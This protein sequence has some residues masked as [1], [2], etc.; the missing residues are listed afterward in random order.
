MRIKLSTRMYLQFSA[1]V[2]PL[3]L[4]LFF[5]TTATSDLP[6]QVA[7]TLAAFDMAL[8]ASSSYKKFLNGVGDAVDTG[9]LGSKALEALAAAHSKTAALVQVQPS[10]VIQKTLEQ[11]AAIEKSV[12]AKNSVETLIALRTDVSNADA[13]VAATIGEVT[14]RLSSIVAEEDQR[15]RRKALRQAG[16]G[17]LTLLI[18]GFIVRQMVI[19]ITR[20]IALAVHTAQLVAK[21]DLSTT[22]EVGRNDEI[23][24]LQQALRDMAEA[25][26]LIVGDVRAGTDVIGQVSGQIGS[27]NL[28]LSVRTEQQTASLQQ[29]SASIKKMTTTVKENADNAQLANQLAASASEVAVK[30]GTVV[31]QVVQTMGSINAS[32]KKIVDIIGVIDSIAFQTNILALNAAV[33]AAR[34]GEQ[35]RGFAVVATEVRNLAQRSAAAAREIKALIGDSVEKV[36]VGGRLVEQAGVTMHEIV[37]SIERVTAIMGEISVASQ[38]QIAGI[39]EVNAAIDQMDYSTK[40]NGAL[41]QEAA[42]ATGLLQGQAEKLS[43]VVRVFKLLGMANEG[44]VAIRE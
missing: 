40:Q 28:D 8:E 6:K 18:L 39:E 9:K 19:G 16:V 5:E 31:S 32:S 41:V 20:P 2:L 15:E 33:E 26:N 7:S 24:A 29:T 38:A 4:V 21:G 25:L 43:G 30:G 17:F 13:S 42:E 11:L 23:G 22:I 36:Q 35:G 34:A 44:S 14:K 3:M 10:A 12:L 27:S 1:A 37:D